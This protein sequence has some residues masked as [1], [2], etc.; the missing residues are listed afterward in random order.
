[1]KA[2]S[3]REKQ[4]CGTKAKH[5]SFTCHQEF[6]GLLYLVVKYLSSGMLDFEENA[7][8]CNFEQQLG[9]SFS[10]CQELLSPFVG[11]NRWVVIADKRD[12]ARMWKQ[13]PALSE[14]RFQNGQRISCAFEWNGAEGS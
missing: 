3:N 9:S 2:V 1:M 11:Q 12:F 10:Q 5:C 13:T 7:I 8:I 14:V 6:R 4:N